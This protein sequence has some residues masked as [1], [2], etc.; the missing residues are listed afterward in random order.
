MITQPKLIC[1]INILG[2]NSMS[3]SAEQPTADAQPKID[4]LLNHS[5]EQ[6]N[7]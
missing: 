4:H 1:E 2:A 3:N 6:I 5:N 7:A